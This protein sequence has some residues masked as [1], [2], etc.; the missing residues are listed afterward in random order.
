L[1]LGHTFHSTVKAPFTDLN[2]ESCFPIS[3]GSEMARVIRDTKV[4]VWDEVSM[5]HKHLMTGLD[6]LFKDLM[7]YDR[8]FGGK[9][10][11]TS[12]DFR[13]NLPIIP[14]GSEAQITNAC[15]KRSPQWNTVTKLGLTE[16][17]RGRNRAES[18]ISSIEQN[19]AFLL[20]MGDGALPNPYP[21][22]NPHLVRLPASMCMSVT[23]DEA[24]M[25]KIVRDVYT[26]LPE[27]ND[28][29]DLLA[30]RSILCPPEHTG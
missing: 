13:Q 23:D 25:S 21:E 7:K 29:P 5:A 9:L 26:Y 1:K 15:L 19:N 2:A 30:E 17:M 28:D 3:A 18:E 22:E 14:G 12:G 24:G 4:F 27:T 20:T 6:L 10:V 8:P 11:F 16:N